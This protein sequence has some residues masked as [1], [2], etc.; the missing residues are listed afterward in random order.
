LSGQG[1]FGR[2]TIAIQAQFRTACSGTPFAI[3]P[4]VTNPGTEHHSEPKPIT[5]A[6]SRPV[7]DEWGVYDPEQAGFEAI[8]RRLEPDDDP[9]ALAWALPMS[10]ATSIRQP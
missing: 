8:A 6:A 3:P 7:C 2:L 10:S 5:S 1:P 9:G 4:I